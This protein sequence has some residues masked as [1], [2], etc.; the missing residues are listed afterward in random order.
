LLPEKARDCI[1]DCYCIAID[2]EI[3]YRNRKKL[4]KHLEEFQTYIESNSH[5][6]TNYGENGV[7][8]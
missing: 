7:S 6:I 3:K 2:D 1:E 5:I 8:Q 4:I